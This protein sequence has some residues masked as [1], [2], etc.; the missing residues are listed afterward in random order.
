[1][2][3]EGQLHLWCAKCVHSPCPFFCSPG[4]QAHTSSYLW[5]CESWQPPPEA[6][7]S[8]PSDFSSLILHCPPACMAKGLS[9]DY[10]KLYTQDK[11]QTWLFSHE[12][13]SLAQTGICSEFA[14]WWY[15]QSSARNSD[16][17][18]FTCILDC[19]F[20][21]M[22]GF[23]H[24]SQSLIFPSCKAPNTCCSPYLHILPR[25]KCPQVP[26]HLHHHSY[27]PSQELSAHYWYEIVDPT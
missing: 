15:F 14:L 26:I 18:A 21:H 16:L 7:K 9:I 8:L 13:L 19:I 27:I 20:L 4:Q 10:F 5:C 24:I 17:I 1:M 6:L 3:A 25:C 11:L 22:Y 23:Y 12:L 2:V